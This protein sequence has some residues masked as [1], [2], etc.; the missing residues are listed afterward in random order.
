[1]CA[2]YK[3]FFHHID[4]HMKTM[5]QLLRSDRAPAEIMSRLAG[6]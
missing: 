3:K 2:A 5:A 6:K 1:L 4:P